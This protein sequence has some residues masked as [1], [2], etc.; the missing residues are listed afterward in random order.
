[1]FITEGGWQQ[2]RFQFRMWC[3]LPKVE[4][5]GTCLVKVFEGMAYSFK[6]DLSWARV[7]LRKFDS[8][9]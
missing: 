1:M 3:S 6:M 8:S 2:D 7:V 9:K 4:A 5:L